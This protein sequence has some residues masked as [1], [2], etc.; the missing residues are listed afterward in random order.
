MAKRKKLERELR[1]ERRI[2]RECYEMLCEANRSIFDLEAQMVVARRW[3]AAWK[4][5]AKGLR[6]VRQA[7]TRQ[8]VRRDE[9]IAALETCAFADK[10]RILD[11]CGERILKLE[12]GNAQCGDYVL[13]LEQ[14]RDAARQTA[15]N[16][17]ASCEAM[18]VDL[19]DANER[20]ATLEGLLRR[21]DAMFVRVLSGP[22][23]DL[24]CD[25]RA[26]LGAAPT[27]RA[28]TDKPAMW[29]YPGPWQ[30]GTPCVPLKTGDETGATVPTEPAPSQSGETALFDTTTPCKT[31]RY[32]V[33]CSR[34][35]TN[36]RDPLQPCGW[37]EAKPTTPIDTR[38]VDV[39]AR[40]YEHDTNSEGI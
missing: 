24:Q 19:N 37:W 20:I 1:L 25:T 31:C 38:E 29:G 2:H 3:S 10:K 17:E 8:I 18:S 13:K 34:C 12:R 23:H 39:M 11:A 30:D 33:V 5:R 35:A 4:R 40:V 14:Q 27:E 28:V 22:I 36:Q 15:V 6:T 32:R 7:M 9:R 26:A 21:W 16:W